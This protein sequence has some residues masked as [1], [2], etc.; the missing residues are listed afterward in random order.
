MDSWKRE[1][2]FAAVCVVSLPARLGL[3]QGLHWTAEDV[4]EHQFPKLRLKV[5]ENL[6]QLAGGTQQLPICVPE[7]SLRLFWQYLAA[8]FPYL[9]KAAANQA[10]Q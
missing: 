10:S 8:S 9:G 6:V 1:Q 7:V 4:Q 3:L 5:R 2:L